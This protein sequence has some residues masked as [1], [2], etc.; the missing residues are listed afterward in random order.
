[1]CVLEVVA[2][3]L[4][5]D[6]KR[7]VKDRNVLEVD[8]LFLIATTQAALV[9][10]TL[11]FQFC[12]LLM[13][14]LVSMSLSVC[15]FVCLGGACEFEKCVGATCKGGGCT[16]IDPSETLKQGYCDGH[17]CNINNIPHPDFEGYLTV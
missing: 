16:F 4:I 14:A 3:L 15:L 2:L 11:C 6:L 1:M 8:V 13:Y 9:S 17:G 5:V 12:M 7:T 10:L